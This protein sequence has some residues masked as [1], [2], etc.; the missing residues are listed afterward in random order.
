MLF[1]RGCCTLKEIEESVRIDEG[2]ALVYLSKLA[3]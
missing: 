3:K 2:A 1:R